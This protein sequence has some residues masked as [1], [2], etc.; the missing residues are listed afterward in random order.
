MQNRN[1]WQHLTRALAFLLT[2][3]LSVG[4][5]AHGEAG[6]HVQEF[7]KHLDDY[8]TEV[9]ALSATL[10]RLA[11]AYAAG[12]KGADHL[13]AFI[14]QWEKVDFHAAVEVVATPLYPPVWAGISRLRQA[15]DEGAPAAEVRRHGD[16]VEAALR[17]GLGALR[18]AAYR[19][20][21]APPAA[22][23]AGHE[24]HEESAGTAEEIRRIVQALDRALQEYREGRVERANSLV[25]AAYLHRFEGLEGDLIAQDPELVAGL[26]EDF[27]GTLP[28]LMAS[29]APADEVASLADV[30]KSK[31]READKLLA[32]SGDDEAQVF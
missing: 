26:E 29:G 27:N 8:A 30:M 32:E 10:D 31:L 6:D 4:A 14:Q 12:E 17:E 5:H 19:R 13:D 18:Y 9:E 21:A 24:R 3:T 7:H 25:Q 23:A 1:H 2:T 11:D 15:I 22:A 28:N 16:V 20:R